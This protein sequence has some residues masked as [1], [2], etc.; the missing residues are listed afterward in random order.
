MRF[1]LDAILVVSLLSF[2][3]ACNADRAPLDEP[4]W[5]DVQ[6]GTPLDDE[7]LGVTIDPQGSVY[8]TGYDN[9]ENGVINEGPVGD[10][11]AFVMRFGRDGALGWRRDLE[12]TA[13][14][15]G[16]RIVRSQTDGH[17]FVAGSTSGAFVGTTNQGSFDLFVSELDTDGNTLRTVQLG[18]EVGEHSAGLAVSTQGVFLSAQDEV[19]VE[20]RAV[21]AWQDASAL[22]LDRPM[23]SPTAAP[24][25]WRH[26]DSD[27]PDFAGG[28]AVEADGSA[29]Y[30][31]GSVSAGAARG[32]YVSRLSST[33]EIVWSTRISPIGADLATA[34]AIAPDGGLYVVG[35]TLGQVGP[36]IV[37]EQ[38]AFVVRVDRASGEITWSAQVGSTAS[39]LPWALA[40]ASDGTIVIAGETLGTIDP[41][42][43]Y[44]GSGDAFALAIDRTTGLVLHAW[45]GATEGD[46]VAR[47]IAVDANGHAYVAGYTEGAIVAGATPRGGRD[48]FVVRAW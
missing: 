12:T 32:P 44:A 10:A 36:Q 42:R 17:L 26:Q 45:Q 40:F 21:T 18:R 33:G 37:G 7:A 2:L 6:L 41:A 31:A 3:C 35:A 25:W 1:R 27:T 14:D 22:V 29:I 34:I 43:P 30:V 48:L 11:H 13:A 20:G 46:D 39:D 38:D 5:L 4:T 16:E 28:V 9:G 23:A 24:R 47:T 8:L 15:L 19:K